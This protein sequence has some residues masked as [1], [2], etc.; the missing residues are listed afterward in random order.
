MGGSTRTSSTFQP[1]FLY[2]LLFNLILA[3]ILFVLFRRRTFRPPG[4]FA[5]YVAGYSGFRIFEE[6]LRV[7]PSHHFLGLRL[8]FFVATV[9][10]LA[11]LAFFAWTQRRGQPDPAAAQQS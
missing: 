3:A 9:L 2:E 11:G 6:T 1:T 10:C 7:D 4:L 5:L 8:N